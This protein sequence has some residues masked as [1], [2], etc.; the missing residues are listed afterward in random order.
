MTFALTH[1]EPTHD[2]KGTAFWPTPLWVTLAELEANPI[3][4]ELV[5]EPWAGTGA[6]CQPLVDAGHRV[7]PIEI[8]EECREQLGDICGQVI[9]GDTLEVLR[10][11]DPDE[12]CTI[13]SNPPWN[14]M[15]LCVP[16]VIAAATMPYS[17]SNVHD[18]RLLLPHRFVSGGVKEPMTIERGRFL[19]RVPPKQW[20]PLYRRPRFAD[21]G[22]KDECG[23]LNWGYMLPAEIKMIG[24]EVYERMYG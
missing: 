5:I 8:R 10:T 15:Y 6:M 13:M 2:D 17:L 16:H 12:P 9:I 22:G 23:F 14:P 7:L 20:H 11:L 3:Q 21:A 24:R 18:C 4:T 1:P 19:E